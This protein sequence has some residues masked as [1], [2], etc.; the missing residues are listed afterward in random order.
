MR[1]IK[2][3]KYIYAKMAYYL[4]INDNNN[5]CTVMIGH[6]DG[7]RSGYLRSRMFQVRRYK[8]GKGILIEAK[9]KRKAGKISGTRRKRQAGKISGAGRKR[10]AGKI[11]RRKGKRKIGR[12]EREG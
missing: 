5:L 6:D 11:S 4:C 9:G 1:P 10:K 3:D 2:G 7:S 12:T 8:K